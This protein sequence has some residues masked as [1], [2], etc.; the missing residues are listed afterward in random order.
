MVVYTCITGN[1][2]A[3]NVDISMYWRPYVD[4]MR[5]MFMGGTYIL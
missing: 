3:F 2:G 5:V 4:T 1:K